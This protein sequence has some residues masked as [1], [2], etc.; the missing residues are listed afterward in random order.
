MAR[1]NTPHQCIPSKIRV[2]S[3]P[4]LALISRSRH[5]SFTMTRTIAASMPLLAVKEPGQ[6]CDLV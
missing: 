5:Y 6:S 1:S 3:S 2:R 4:I